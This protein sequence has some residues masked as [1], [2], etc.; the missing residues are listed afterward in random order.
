MR[1]FHYYL[2]V[3]RQTVQHIKGQRNSCLRLLE[4]ESIE[5]LKNRFDFLFTPKFLS[6]FLC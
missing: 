5:S 4:G 1:T 6:V 2:N 3:F